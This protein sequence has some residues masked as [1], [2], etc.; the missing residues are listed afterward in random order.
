MVAIIDEASERRLQAEHDVLRFGD[1]FL[2][3]SLSERIA[4]CVQSGQKWTE[5]PLLDCRRSQ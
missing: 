3:W 2:D 4:E 1:N 5:P